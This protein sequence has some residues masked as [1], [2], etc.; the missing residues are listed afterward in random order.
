MKVDLQYKA[1]EPALPRKYTVVANNN[2][3]VT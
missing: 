2:V 1:R 3:L